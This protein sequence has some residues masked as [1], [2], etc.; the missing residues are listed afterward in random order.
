[1][2]SSAIESDVLLARDGDEAAFRRLV[3][4]SANTVCSIALAI[5]RNVHASEDVAQEAFIATW[6]RL[7]ELRNPASFMPWLR[8]VTRNQAHLWRRENSREVGDDAKIEAAIDARPSADISYIADEEQR[9]LNEVLDE[10]PDEAREVLVLYY[11]EQ[12]ST[13]QV[14]NLLEIS[15]EAVRQRLSRSRAL[16]REEMLERF[17]RSVTRTAP[18]AAFFA[19][20]AGAMTFAAPSASAAVVVSTSAK[21]ASGAA[22]A[23]ILKSIALGGLFGWFGVFMGMQELLPFHDEQEARELRKFR[24]IVLAVITLGSIAIAFSVTQSW[25]M[26]LFAIQAT[27]IAIGYLYLMRLPRILERRMQ[28]EQSLNPDAAK[29]SRRQWM[30][31]T[32]GRALGA[33]TGG[34]VLMAMFLRAAVN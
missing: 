5:T 3:E 16:L 22:G 21:A 2:N 27:Y 28:W 15:E 12:S 31:A 9:V 24:D 8:Q 11:R 4:R 26:S 17:G 7:K 18:G 30:W 14:A 25:L 32:T 34:A 10:L 19:A 20:V 1:M 13:R 6:T 29:Q 33:A 23:A